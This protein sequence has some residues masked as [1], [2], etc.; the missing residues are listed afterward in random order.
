LKVH[1]RAGESKIKRDI[2]C[3]ASREITFIA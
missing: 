2:D 1:V 3:H